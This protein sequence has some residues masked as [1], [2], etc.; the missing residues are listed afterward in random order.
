MVPVFFTRAKIYFFSLNSIRPRRLVQAPEVKLRTGSADNVDYDVCA[1][2]WIHHNT[3]RTY[4]NECVD[5]KEGSENNL[6][7]YN[8]C[9][10]QKDENSGCFGFRG[11]H[12]TARY[13][14]I[15]NCEGAGVRVGGDKVG[16]TTFGMGNHMYGNTIKNTGNGAFNVMRPEQGA[17]CENTISG[18][19]AVSTFWVDKVW[20][21]AVNHA[22]TEIRSS[23]ECINFTRKQTS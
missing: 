7:E 14:D 12:N 19:T 3:F 20:V 8:I 17:V 21:D 13:N 5:V 22:I 16:S 6:I 4:A 1:Y 18:A 9:E 15:T 23:A 2:N 10:E 11:S